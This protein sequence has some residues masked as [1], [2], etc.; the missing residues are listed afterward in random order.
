MSEYSTKWPKL[1]FL[2]TY[3]FHLFLTQEH[4]R[5]SVLCSECPVLSYFNI[6]ETGR[7]GGVCLTR[8]KGEN[9]CEN[10]GELV[11]GM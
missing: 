4:R 5:D 11:T 3:F 10:E 8:D 2:S 7:I 6:E 1:V 9:E